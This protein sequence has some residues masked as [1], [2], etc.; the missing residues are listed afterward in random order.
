MNIQTVLPVLVSWT[1]HL[2]GHP[3][4]DQPPIVGFEPHSFFAEHVCGGRE[5]DAVGWYNDQRVI[6]IDEKYRDD[7]GGFPS[8]LLVHELTDYLQHQSANFDSHSCE[9]SLAREREAYHVQ[10]SYI[11]Q[12]QASFALIRP[13]PTS[14]NYG[15]AAGSATIRTS[16]ELT[17]R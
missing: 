8:S 15:N 17:T 6:Y 11:L 4:P 3:M 2:S 12:G 5:C 9:D 16:T 7:D 10:N 1:S 13:A 14:C